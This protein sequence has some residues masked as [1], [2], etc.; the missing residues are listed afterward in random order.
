MTKLPHSLPTFDYEKQALGRGHAIVAGVDEAG[1]GPLAGPVVAAAVVIPVHLWSILSEMGFDDS[2][3]LT[4]RRREDLMA[5][6]LACE[7]VDRA[8]G[9]CSAQEI[10]KLNILRATHE[11]MRRALVGLKNVPDF[12]LV[13]GLPVVGLPCSHEA[14][15][16][17]DGLVL[18][19]AVASI[20]A[21]VTR[22]KIMIE[23]DNEFP[24][25]GFAQHKGYGTRA[26]LKAIEKYEPCPIHRRTFGPVAQ[27]Q[28]PLF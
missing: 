6:L 28:L 24:Q 26:H 25:Y 23:A 12:C 17:G 19:I 10:D 3:K 14:I 5:E 11:A 8:V 1:R 21:K 20:L 22:D 18:S 15:V 9:Q 16:K 7:G 4:A 2:K 27:M 13:D